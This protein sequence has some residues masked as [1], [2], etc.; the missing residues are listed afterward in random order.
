MIGLV[1]GA[2]GPCTNA[3]IDT[4]KTRMQ[5]S[6]ALPGESGM[7]RVRHIVEDML[8]KEGPSALYKGILPRVLRVG[9][10]QAVA[11][12]AYEKIAT[13]LRE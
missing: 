1:A 10:G 3:P 7:Q 2:A 11:Y 13:F 9:P 12:A 8:R 4:I 5:K 6:A